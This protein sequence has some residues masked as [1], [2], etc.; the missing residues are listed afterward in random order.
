MKVKNSA[1]IGVAKKQRDPEQIV[2]LST[3]YRARLR[4]VSAG[5]IAE[6]QQSVKYPTPP[7][8]YNEAA[9]REEE[10]PNHPAYIAE[11]ENIEMQRNLVGME[12]LIMFGVEL[13]DE[14]GN[15][16]EIDIE[17]DWVRRLRFMERRGVISLE[18]LDLSDPIDAE[19]AFKK[20]IAVGALDMDTI[21][22][23]TI[24]SEEALEEAKASFR[25]N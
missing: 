23:A 7:T 11:V 25:D 16:L 13:V 6:A 19:F 10:N 4:S 14:E 17:A 18:G 2:M 1:V 8:W 20:Y 15:Q 3:G 9:G 22:S 21:T 24:V 12:A 5:L